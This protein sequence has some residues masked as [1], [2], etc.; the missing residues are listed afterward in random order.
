A[1]IN[2]INLTTAR[3]ASR[4]DEVGLRKVF[5]ARRKNLIRQ[6]L[7]E[8][9]VFSI[10]SFILAVVMVKAVIPVLNS[11][12][13]GELR[14]S[15]L[16]P[17]FFL[18]FLVITI[19]VGILAGIYPALFLSSC[20][21][22][23]ILKGEK[24]SGKSGSVFRNILVVTQFVIA[25]ALVSSTIVVFRQINFMKDRDLGFNKE[26]ILVIPVSNN[27]IRSQ[28]STIKNELN[29][30]PGIINT[31]V[32]SHVPGQVTYKNPF[33]P[34]GFTKDQ[35]Q[36][37]GSLLID[38]DYLSTM[39]IE[40]VNGRAFSE[41]FSTDREISVLINETAAKQFG[42][43]DPVG[44][45]IISVQGSDRNNWTTTSVIGVVK[46]FHLTSLHQKI[47]PL[48]ISNAPFNLNTISVKLNKNNI[49]SIIS[50]LRIKWKN[51]SPDTPFDFFF[52]DEF[53]DRQYRN[54][55]RLGKIFTYFTF[56][57]IFIAVLGVFG[58][59]S[60]IVEKR[61]KEI[62]IRKVLGA[63][64]SQILKN[65][66]SQFTTLVI[67]ACLIAVPL[68]W[69]VMSR[70][71]NNFAYRTS[72]S[73]DIF[74]LSVMIIFSIALLTVIIHAVRAAMANPVDS[75]RNE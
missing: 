8:S 43:E 55:E 2:C 3:S 30:L 37:M 45:E 6:F 11:L 26:Q 20:E 73:P 19:M 16:E 72:L 13:G 18:S 34:E 12:T 47:E 75:L 61:S 9:T 64:I 58:L 5:G 46:D 68:T 7:G 69:F 65:L 56:L 53:F 39:N 50:S 31:A 22:V 40:I 51:I 23:K 60:Y 38:E 4:A 32:S 29:S 54:D 33:I 52:L 41:E 62:G 15:I 27:R 24:V 70:W 21:P 42:W 44:K 35:M 49:S 66:T 67:S 36:F 14:Y 48:I 17:V 59:V 1:C 57:A 10:I 71:L 74:V 25:A 28:L 63:S